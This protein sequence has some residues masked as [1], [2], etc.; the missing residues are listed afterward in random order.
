M[1]IQQMNKQHKEQVINNVTNALDDVGSSMLNRVRPLIDLAYEAGYNQGKQE[2]N[3][4]YYQ[5]IKG[6]DEL[7]STLTMPEQCWNPRTFKP[8]DHKGCQMCGIG[9]DGKAYGY[10]CTR[11]DCPTRVTF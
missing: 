1:E 10:V 5:A 3:T 2:A 6:A 8:I 4:G 11:N 9:A 7:K